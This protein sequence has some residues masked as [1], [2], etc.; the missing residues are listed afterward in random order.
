M[1]S[2]SKLIQYNELASYCK[3]LDID[4]SI[5]NYFYCKKRKYHVNPDKFCQLCQL[6]KHSK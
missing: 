5:L 1:S 2:T 6:Y 3:E 4:N